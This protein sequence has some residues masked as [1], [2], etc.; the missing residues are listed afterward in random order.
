R[1]P[2][3]GLTYDAQKLTSLAAL[4]NAGTQLSVC[5]SFLTAR[6]TVWTGL[7][8]VMST[9]SNTKPLSLKA[10]EQL[11]PDAPTPILQRTGRSVMIGEC[12]VAPTVR[13]F[14]V[15]WRK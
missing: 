4:A 10:R 5:W 9:T 11:V 14:A 7:F 1:L 3:L 15:V 6:S 8:A 2:L 13:V 12:G